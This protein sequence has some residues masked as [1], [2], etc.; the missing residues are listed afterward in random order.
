[1]HWKKKI[2]APELEQGFDEGTMTMSKVIDDV[3]KL[4]KNKLALWKSQPIPITSNIIHGFMGTQSWVRL[5]L[6]CTFIVW[7]FYHCDGAQ[8]VTR[9][10]NAALFTGRYCKS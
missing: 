6:V 7:L 1:M 3:L 2:H 8:Y 5:F 9:M 10:P 4:A